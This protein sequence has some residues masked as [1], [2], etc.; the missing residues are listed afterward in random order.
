MLEKSKAE[1]KW[2]P[3]ALVKSEVKQRQIS[4]TWIDRS[5]SFLA[6]SSTF[7][8]YNTDGQAI[9]VTVINRTPTG[10]ANPDC[11]CITDACNWWRVLN[12]TDGD[13]SKLNDNVNTRR[14]NEDSQMLTKWCPHA[15]PENNL[16][17]SP[18][19]GTISGNYI[20]IASANRVTGNA[21]HPGSLCITQKCM[22]YT[23]NGNPAGPGIGYCM[24]GDKNMQ[25]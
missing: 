5:S 1:T 16:D 9:A 10:E 8:T 18:V 7:A 6:A 15:R 12:G 21:V 17:T 23:T 20:A 4:G 25:R 3:F 22:A 19:S 14:D 11:L 13:C 24:S 2:C